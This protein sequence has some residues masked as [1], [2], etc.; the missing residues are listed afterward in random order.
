M[1]ARRPDPE[2]TI[3]NAAGQ[4]VLSWQGSLTNYQLQS[5]LQLDPTAEWRAVP[6]SPALFEGR[7]TVTNS[8]NAER[9]FF[10]LAR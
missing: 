2:L 8:L 1:S 3:R 5:T 7:H 9:R 4:L 10:R 6:E